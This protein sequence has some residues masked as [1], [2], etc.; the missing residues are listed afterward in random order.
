MHVGMRIM[1][2]ERELSTTENPKSLQH[3]FSNQKH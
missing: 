3:I 1:V 2:V